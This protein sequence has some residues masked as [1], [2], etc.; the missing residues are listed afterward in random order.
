M[1]N[2]KK[3]KNLILFSLI[4]N[5]AL[6]A[7]LQAQ[8]EN[9]ESYEEY[10]LGEIV[11]IG[12]KT[13]AVREVTKTTIVTAE[14]LKDKNVRTVAEALIYVAGLRVSTGRKNEPNVSIHG[15]EQTRILVLIDGVP[16]Y[17][18]KFGRLDLNAI[19]IDNIAKI[20]IEKGVSSILY[21]PNSLGGVINIITKKPTEKQHLEIL[22][23]RRDYET[24]RTSV[25]LGKKLTK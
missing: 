18:T 10:A 6:A 14:E 20:E 8:Q 17:E 24:Y 3:I 16:Y 23:E 15:L 11:V 2:S 22:L 19:P 4:F 21:G 7:E 9:T 12:E 25:S 13:P 5:L 1:V